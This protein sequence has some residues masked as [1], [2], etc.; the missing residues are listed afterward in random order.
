MTLL[1]KRYAVALHLAAKAAGSVGAVG[2]DLEGLHLAIQDP[3]VQK[4]WSSPEISA[5]ER[6]RIAQ[7]LA[8]GKSP[9]VA[10]LLQVLLRR[11]RQEVLADLQ[12]AYRALVMA[13]RG[14]V[15]GVVESPLPLGA[16][17]VAQ[18]QQ[19]AHRLSG[20][21]CQLSVKVRPE[22]IGGVRLI[23]GNVLFDGSLKSA[24]E[25]LEQKLLQASV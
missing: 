1:A 14:E 18:L 12:P 22:L 6:T 8:A 16:A 21:Q 15:E 7:K 20:K 4:M 24:L 25:Q 19:L 2:N 9:L 5:Q 3:T 13:E 23:V 11:R 17:D 10:N